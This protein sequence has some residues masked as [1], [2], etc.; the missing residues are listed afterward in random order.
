[1]AQL[2]T[3]R[4]VC[5]KVALSRTT[6]FRL[7]RRGDFPEPVKLTGRRVAYDADAVEKW[8]A[9]RLEGEVA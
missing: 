3:T 7:V 8:I 4:A 1:M 5:D 2:L 6:L 9:E